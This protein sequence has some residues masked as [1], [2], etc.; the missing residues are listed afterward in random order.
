MQNPGLADWRISPGS[1]AATP[2]SLV[3]EDGCEELV[4][5]HLSLQEFSFYQVVRLSEQQ[6]LIPHGLQGRARLGIIN[7]YRTSWY[8]LA[9]SLGQLQYSL[10]LAPGESVNLA[11]IDWSRRDK[12]ARTEDTK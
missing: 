11:V 8:P 6:D 4:P 2:R 5:A 12:A 3:G 9:P 7:E 1:F 10:P